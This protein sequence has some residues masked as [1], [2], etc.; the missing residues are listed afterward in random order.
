MKYEVKYKWLNIDEVVVEA[1]SKE[2]AEEIARAR[3]HEYV[4]CCDAYDFDCDLNKTN[5]EVTYRIY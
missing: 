4:E 5:K 2:E 3:L 1:D